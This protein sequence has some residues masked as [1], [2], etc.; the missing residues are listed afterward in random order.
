M[1]KFEAGKTYL[2]RSPGDYNCV[3]TVKVV[4]RTAKTIVTDEGKRLKVHTSRY[5]GEEYVMPWGSYSLAPCISAEKE[6]TE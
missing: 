4:K 1:K 6:V 5:D 3:I 2:G